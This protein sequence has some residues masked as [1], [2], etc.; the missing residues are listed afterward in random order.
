MIMRNRISVGWPTAQ[1]ERLKRFMSL[2]NDNSVA[3]D[4]IDW[5]RH[6]EERSDEAI[7]TSL[8]RDGL[9]R[10][11]RNDGRTQND[12]AETTR[13]F[14]AGSIFCTP[15]ATTLAPSLTPP[16]ITTALLS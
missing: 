8:W 4:V 12:S 16:A 6:C 14:W 2:S 7:H 15:S 3:K 11:A 1:P 10:C 5:G 9:L 13:T